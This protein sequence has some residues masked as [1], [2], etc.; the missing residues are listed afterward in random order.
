MFQYRSSEQRWCW[1]AN[2]F[3]KLITTLRFIAKRRCVVAA[4]YDWRIGNISRVVWSYYHFSVIEEHRWMW[5]AAWVSWMESTTLKQLNI[6]KVYNVRQTRDLC[7]NGTLHC[8]AAHTMQFCSFITA[9]TH[10]PHVG[11]WR[12]CNVTEHPYRDLLISYLL[13]HPSLFLV[14][15]LWN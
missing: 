14:D 5:N 15:T 6:T 12:I 8:T 13:C 4:W 7:R 11:W 3:H 9:C 10:A 2:A 1:Y